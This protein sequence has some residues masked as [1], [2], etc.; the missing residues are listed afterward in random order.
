MLPNV[1]GDTRWTFD[2]GGAVADP[3]L[4]QASV[5][6]PMKVNLPIAITGFHA[7]LSQYWAGPATAAALS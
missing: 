3:H 5:S 7:S 4:D 2:G 1:A 6:L